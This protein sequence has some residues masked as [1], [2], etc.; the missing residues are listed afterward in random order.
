[1]RPLSNC[2]YPSLPLHYFLVLVSEPESSA[3]ILRA[4]LCA[5]SRPSHPP[6]H[7][8]AIILFCLVK[9][10]LLLQ[11]ENPNQHSG[12]LSCMGISGPLKDNDVYEFGNVT[13]QKMLPLIY[14]TLFDLHNSPVTCSG[15]VILFY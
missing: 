4:I 14:L 11:T 13:V 12:L 6:P 5:S 8:F 1:M 9:S 7:F 2:C 15:Q 10:F 3:L